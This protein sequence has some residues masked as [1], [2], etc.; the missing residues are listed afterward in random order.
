MDA[1]NQARSAT[2]TAGTPSYA[3]QGTERKALA[4]LVPHI[5]LVAE[6]NDQSSARSGL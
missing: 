5:M 4:L 2:P 1:A 6:E 3:D